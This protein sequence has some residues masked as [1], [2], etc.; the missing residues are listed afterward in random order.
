M[1]SQPSISFDHVWKK[2]RLG[3]HHDSLRDLIPSALGR[4]RKA[5]PEAQLVGKEFWALRD[6]SFTV[7][8]GQAL[9]IIGRNGAGKSTALKLLTRILRPTLGTTLVRGRVGAL[10]E[11][12]AGFH[13]DLTGR[14]NIYL[15]GAIMG[16]RQVDIARRFDAI[17]EFAD[18][19]TFIDTQVKRYSS[20]MNARLGFSIAA[21]MDPEVLLIDEVLAVGDVSFQ[22]KCYARLQEYRRQGMPIVFVSHNMQAILSLCDRVLLLRPEAPWILGPP[23]EVLDAYFASGQHAADARVTVVGSSIGEFQGP[24]DAKRS[25]T[26]GTSMRLTLRLIANVDLTSLGIAF[27][28]HRSDGMLVFD[29]SSTLDGVP[30]V[31]VRQGGELFSEIV[32][33]ANVLKGTYRVS[34]LLFEERRSWA[35]VELGTLGTFAVHERTRAGGVAELEPSY[36]LSVVEGG[37]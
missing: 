5:Q 3:E 13:P 8:P 25:V 22:E 12:A 33:K 14:E 37:E 19:T 10:I 9:G 21:H 23:G 18:I 32:F 29:G 1:S 24:P 2:F 4:L 26:P 16:M 6:V 30:V 17:V 15:Q 27:H 35:S 31:D 11:V 20:G 7:E 34:A 28:V 36:R